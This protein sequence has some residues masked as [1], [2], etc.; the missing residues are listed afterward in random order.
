MTQWYDARMGR[1]LDRQPLRCRW[2]FHQASRTP[3]LD[4]KMDQSDR[5][6]AD[7]VNIQA[8]RYCDLCGA[9]L[10]EAWTVLSVRVRMSSNWLIGGPTTGQCVWGPRGPDGDQA[11]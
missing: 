4:V 7:R 8:R 11:A 10:G 9:D 2:G 3:F 5:D 6:R 1:W